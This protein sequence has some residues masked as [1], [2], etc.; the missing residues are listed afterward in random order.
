[1]AF[2]SKDG[3]FISERSVWAICAKHP[4]RKACLT[5]F[6]FY[7]GWSVLITL[8]QQLSHCLVAALISLL[9]SGFAVPCVHKEFTISYHSSKGKFGERLPSQVCTRLE[10]CPVVQQVF[11]MNISKCNKRF[12]TKPSDRN[13][14]ECCSY[15]SCICYQALEC[16][17]HWKYLLL[18]SSP[19]Q[20]YTNISPKVHLCTFKETE[21]SEIYELSF[22]P[23]QFKHNQVCWEFQFRRA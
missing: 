1:M 9:L 18:F 3:Y 16:L 23:L 14:L 22:S 11:W 2:I 13:N 20:F 4:Q 7:L 8:H 5:S 12:F 10:L 17:Y 15:L 21:E 6:F 19:M